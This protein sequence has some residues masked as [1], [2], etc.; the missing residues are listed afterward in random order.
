ME[1]HHT[2]QLANQLMPPRFLHR[3]KM[4]PKL[5]L[6][7]GIAWNL[8]FSTMC[9]IW[10]LPRISG[11]HYILCTLQKKILLVFTSSIKIC[12]LSSGVIAQLRNIFLSSKVC[13][14][15][16]MFISHWL[17]TC[18]NS[19]STRTNFE[20]PNFYLV[21]N[22]NLLLSALKYYL[23]RTYPV[24]V[25]LML[26][27]EEHLFLLQVSRMSVLLL[28]FPLGNIIVLKGSVAV[29]I[30]LVLAEVPIVV[31]VEAMAE[32]SR[33]FLIV[34]TQITLLIFVGN[35]MASPRGPITP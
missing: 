30:S 29:I 23:A 12:S 13:G 5:W 19:K 9:H 25:K 20:S 33:S 28:L 24:L 32:V 18:R 6:N 16:L 17:L 14:M 27:L 4:M 2:L 1:K 3:F 22:P 21:W 26:R 35:F 11:L 31:V 10:T 8:M 34:A 7:N 15:N